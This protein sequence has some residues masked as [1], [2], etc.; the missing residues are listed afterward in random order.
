MIRKRFEQIETSTADDH[1]KKSFLDKFK[2]KR[3]LE[4]DGI[5]R[6]KLPAESSPKPIQKKETNDLGRPQIRPNNQVKVELNSLGQE[7][8][9][10]EQRKLERQAQQEVLQEQKRKVLEREIQLDMTKEKAQQAKSKLFWSFIVIAVA[11]FTLYQLSKTNLSGRGSPDIIFFIFMIVA[12]IFGR[13][14]GRW[15]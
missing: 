5:E 14:R 13:G 7:I 3:K 8:E 11:V 4:L 9:I 10:A 6:E 15:R 12:A 1:K 2:F